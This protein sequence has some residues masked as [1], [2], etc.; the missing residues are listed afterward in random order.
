M[1]RVLRPMELFTLEFGKAMTKKEKFE[2][3]DRWVKDINPK[4]Y[5]EIS[6]GRLGNK[7][8]IATK[9]EENTGIHTWT[10]YMTLNEMEQALVLYFD[11]DFNK[12][13]DY[14]KE[15]D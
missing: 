4:A 5:L 10:N 1:E 9:L 8:A 12:L 11:T 14:G 7:V 15:K 6:D 2:M 3:L 13:K